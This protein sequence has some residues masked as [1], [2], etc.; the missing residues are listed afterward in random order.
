MLA[1]ALSAGSQMCL[2]GTWQQAGDKTFLKEAKPSCFSS[3]SA[4]AM[5]MVPRA[6]PA[7]RLHEG[8]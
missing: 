7:P 2:V 3:P 8:G 6:M 5:A 1:A 4:I